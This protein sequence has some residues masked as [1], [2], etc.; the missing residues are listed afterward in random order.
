MYEKVLIAYEKVLNLISHQ[1]NIQI[2]MRRYY[3][4][5]IRL[6]KNNKSNCIKDCKDVE[7]QRPNTAGSSID[8]QDQLWKSG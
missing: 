8:K 4:T 1:K 7:Q 2:T 6:E 3:Y 5:T